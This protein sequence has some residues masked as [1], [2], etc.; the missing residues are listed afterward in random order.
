MNDKNLQAIME[1]IDTQISSRTDQAIREVNML[2]YHQI[3]AEIR[4]LE[5]ARRIIVTATGYGK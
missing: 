3:T 4:G 1:E 2:H 5:L